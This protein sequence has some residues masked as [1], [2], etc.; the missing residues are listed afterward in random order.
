MTSD[1]G[2]RVRSAANDD[3]EV[4]D[5]GVWWA[6]GEYEATHSGAQGYV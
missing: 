1:S 2:R 3:Q 5:V 4:Q 6:V